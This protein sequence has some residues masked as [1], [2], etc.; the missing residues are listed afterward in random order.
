MTTDEE[1]LRMIS[2]FHYVL[3]GLGCVFSCFPLIHVVIG[4]ILVFSPETFGDHGGSPPPAFIGWLFFG[5]G[6]TFFLVGQ[7][8]NICILAS[9]RCLAKRSK[10]MFSFVV[11]CIE[12]MLVPL[13][14][15]LGVL[16]IVV[17][18]RGSVKALYGV[19]ADGEKEAP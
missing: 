10:Y 6:V 19:A 5:M 8:I 12:C 9:G 7:C 15:V 18:S 13:G 11:A 4:L 2:I 17:M 3:G 16:T 1:H 14:T